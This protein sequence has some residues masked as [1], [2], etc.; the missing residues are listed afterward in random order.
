MTGR[1]PKLRVGI[2]TGG[3]FT[4]IVCVDAASGA[5][6]VTKVA[7]T[8]S[9]PAI[10]L[11]RGVKAILGDA[12][13]DDLAGLAHGTTVATNALLQGE[14]A[15]LGLIVTEGFRHILEIAR[16]AVP[17]GYGNSYFWVKPARIVPLRHV[18]E[19]GGRL[20]FLGEELRPLDEGSI[21][22]A[23]RYFREQGITTIGV[24]L[25][26]SYANAAHE[27]RVAQLL[28]AD[29][30]D[31]IVSLSCDVL[32]EY[33]EY[34]RAVTTLVDAFV[35]PHMGRYLKRIR[36]ELGPGLRDKPFLVMQ[37]SGGVA[38]P[39]Q[40]MRKPITTAL[41]G[42]AAGAIGSAV[43]AEIAGFPDLVTLDA[44]GTSTDLCLIE[45]AKPS[46]TNGGAVGRF[47]VRV[48]MIDIK[49]IGTG[50]GSIAWTTREGHL[51][52]GPRSAGAEPG[53][54][55]Y[56]NGSNE[57]T[58]TD[59]NLV[60]G[61]IPPALIGGGIRLD[62]ER[63]RAG[64]AALG[65]RL[66]GKMGPEQLAEGII[67]IANWNQANAIRQMTIQRGIDPRKFALLSFGGSGPAQSPAVMDLIG[68]KA[69]I[70][71]P[72]PG[73]LSAFGLLAVDWR[74]DHMVTK[75]THEDMLDSGAVADI[76]AALESD[77]V[78]TLEQDGIARSRIRLAREADVRYAGQ[79]MEVRVPAP[80]GEVDASFIAGTIDAFHAAHRKAFGYNYAGRQKVEIVNFCVSGFGM[81]ER[82]IIPKLAIAADAKPRH[83]T[84]PAY[85]SGAFR[86][87]PIYER[88]S[89]P[90]G[91]RLDGPAVIEEFGSTTVV[92]P[93]QWL[94]L[95]EHGILVVRRETSR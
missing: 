82:P 79:S 7:S 67:E 23:A 21:R 90:T 57:P 81:I 41:S 66:P 12:A 17:E 48:P 58:I 5:M 15:G 62:A 43:I 20:N 37:S 59:A 52:V 45:N 92:F 34:E 29:H 55:C 24:C 80:S 32:P 72:N 6:R 30:P 4:D 89:L 47:P 46:V 78:A 68:M 26:H 44:G 51:K 56:P 40:V 75:V 39:D 38:S 42:P 50:G 87:T 11:V 27:R 94:Q 31:C 84:R 88:A 77:A 49:T 93:D 28:A 73:N 60:L 91:F 85:F 16:Q 1:S 33:R 95:D 64:I 18:R 36:D 35:K 2:D 3:T 76:Y 9:N 63:A 25:L 61:R 69:C 22:A 10:G 8:P 86:D 70:V 13:L 53:P 74:T 14:I 54:M 19:V 71:P 65:A 83:G